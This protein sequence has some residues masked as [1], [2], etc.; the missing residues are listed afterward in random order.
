M[1]PTMDI[2]VALFEIAGEKGACYS[3]FGY[4]NYLLV[5]T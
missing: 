4:I 2:I 1:N 5:D 3:R